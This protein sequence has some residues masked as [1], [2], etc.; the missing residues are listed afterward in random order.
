M[1]D[2]RVPRRRS[3]LLATA[4]ATTAMTGALLAVPAGSAGAATAATAASGEVGAAAKCGN[5]GSTTLIGSTRTSKQLTNVTTYVKGGTVDGIPQRWG[6]VAGEVS[7]INYMIFEVDKTRDGKANC[8][9]KRSVGNA[10]VN[11][12][13]QPA[14][15]GWRFRACWTMISSTTSC[16]GLNSTT[17]WTS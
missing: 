11:T 3:R 4:A 2:A 10:A 13:T 12:L 1:R 6:R 17:S 14:I 9:L 5:T 7:L 8:Y 16:A 15:S